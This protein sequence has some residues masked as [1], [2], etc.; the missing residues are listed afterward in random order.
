ME[1]SPTRWQL[2]GQDPRDGR[3]MIFMT[4]KDI[5]RNPATPSGPT[6]RCHT[7]PTSPSSK[8]PPANAKIRTGSPTTIASAWACAVGRTS[9]ISRNASRCKSTGLPPCHTHASSCVV[10][11]VHMAARSSMASEHRSRC[12][13]MKT[14]GRRRNA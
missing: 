6:C 3:A 12:T 4:R 8:T 7:P 11:A 2:N 14:R 5:E 1:E 9:T 13:V 10:E